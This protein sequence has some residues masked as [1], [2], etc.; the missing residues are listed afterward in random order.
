M[1]ANR[2]NY[3]RGP[4]AAA[5]AGVSVS[6]TSRLNYSRDHESMAE[7]RRMAE[8]TETEILKLK[9]ENRQLKSKNDE[10]RAELSARMKEESMTRYGIVSGLYCVFAL[11]PCLCLCFCLLSLVVIRMQHVQS[12]RLSYVARTTCACSDPSDPKQD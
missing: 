12:V 9:S 1:G 7:I 3:G 10:L 5:S 4:A 8:D 11:V 2:L 6:E